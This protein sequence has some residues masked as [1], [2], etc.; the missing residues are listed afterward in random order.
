MEMMEISVRGWLIITGVII[1]STI[2]IDS[3]R[4]AWR[5]RRQANELSFGLNDWRAEDEEED[6]YG[7]ELP[8]GGARVVSEDALPLDEPDSAQ[9][10]HPGRE[11]RASEPDMPDILSP[12]REARAQDGRAGAPCASAHEASGSHQDLQDRLHQDPMEAPASQPVAQGAETV[13]ARWAEPRVYPSLDAADEEAACLSPERMTVSHH[14][15][16]PARKTRVQKK[17]GKGQEETVQQAEQALPETVLVINVEAR[18]DAPF[19]GEPL[20][21]FF[22]RHGIAFGSRSI[23][24]CLSDEAQD[25]VPAYAREEGQE[26]ETLFSVANGMEP[27]TFELETLPHMTTSGLSFFMALPGPR[28]PHQAFLAMVEAV[29]HLS[30]ETGASLRDEH[31]SVL[32]LQTLDLYKDRIREYER[33]R[34]AAQSRLKT[35]A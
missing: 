1:V 31:H 4:R 23:F 21:A 15:L 5:A 27:G 9:D 18:Q 11:M 2:L 8:N 6:P 17:T 12:G 14:H 22:Q 32:T 24:H 19:H 28:K 20:L 33:R 7:S 29:H 3:L 26:R 13:A 16:P 25:R 30:R 34:L 35:H 10:A